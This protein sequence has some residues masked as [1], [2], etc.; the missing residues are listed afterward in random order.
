MDTVHHR[1][2]TSGRHV[3]VGLGNVKERMRIF[4]VGRPGGWVLVGEGVSNSVDNIDVPIDSLCV[5]T[6]MSTLSLVVEYHII[7]YKIVVDFL[8]ICSS[9]YSEA[10]DVAQCLR[11]ASGSDCL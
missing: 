9:I 3:P 2:V 4:Y 5:R 1:A 11:E 8:C 10:R 6:R 7:Y